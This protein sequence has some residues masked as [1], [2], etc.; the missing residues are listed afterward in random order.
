M[1]KWPEGQAQPHAWQVYPHPAHGPKELQIAANNNGWL[2]KTLYGWRAWQSF[3]EL[4]GPSSRVLIALGTK[5]AYTLWRVVE[6]ERIVTGEDLITLRARG[7]LG[8]L[9]ALDLAAVPMAD[10]KSVEETVE[11]LAHGAYRSGPEAIVDLARSTTQWCLG[12]WLADKR[13]DP[14]LRTRDL[15]RLARLLDETHEKDVAMLIG[16]FHSRAKPN[17]RTRYESR[18]VSEEDAEFALA[19]VA[20]LLRELRWT[21]K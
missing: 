11:R 4:G 12:V 3:R 13:K 1:Y 21:A 5:D 10:Q 9:P 16:R 7:S 6:V 8:V 14:E 17:E 20:L 15:G 19:S 2:N 18:P